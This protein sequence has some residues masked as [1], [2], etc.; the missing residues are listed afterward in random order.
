MMAQRQ[1]ICLAP[2]VVRRLVCYD[3][4]GQTYIKYLT[5]HRQA[6]FINFISICLLN[7]VIFLQTPPFPSKLSVHH[8]WQIIT[9]KH[10][11]GSNKATEYWMIYMVP[12][13]ILIGVGV[14]NNN[15]E[16]I[17]KFQ[18][19][20]LWPQARPIAI[21]TQSEIIILMATVIII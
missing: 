11:C 8:Q 1:R 13:E 6:L 12:E 21:T 9:N 18:L 5:R 15:F 14:G 3:W 19:S 17:S 2:E 16:V 10:R 20:S 7:S 4:G